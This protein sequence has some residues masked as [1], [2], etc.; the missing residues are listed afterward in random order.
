M[1][2]VFSWRNASFISFCLPKAFNEK[3][4]TPHCIYYQGSL[5]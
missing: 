3:M 2:I 5:N 1:G 4:I